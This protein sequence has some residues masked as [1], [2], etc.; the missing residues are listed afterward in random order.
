MAKLKTL[1]LH[2]KENYIIM[3]FFIQEHQRSFNMKLLSD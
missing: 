3:K 1:L 2:H